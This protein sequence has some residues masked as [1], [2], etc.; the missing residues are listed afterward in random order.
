MLRATCSQLLLALVVWSCPLAA[1]E[2]PPPEVRTVGTTSLRYVVRVPAGHA[3][4]KWVPML[5]VFSSERGENHASAAAAG[6]ASVVEAG[7]VV[8]APVLE[9]QGVPDLRPLFTEL[10]RM[11]RIDQGGMHVLLQGDGEDTVAV[12]LAHRHQFQTVSSAAPL[13]EALTRLPARRI[14]RTRA[15]IPSTEVRRPVHFT[16]L[17]AERTLPGVAGEIARVLD[18]FHD[19]AANADEARYFAILPDDAVFLGTDGTERWTGTEFRAFA[20]RYFERES[21]WTYVTLRREVNVEPGDTIA[22]FDESFDNEAYG[23]CRGSGVMAKR[24]G[25]WVL[26]QYH[27]TVP[28]P[29][30]VTREVAARIRAF[31][32]G[33]TMGRDPVT[34]I[35][36]VRHAEKADAGEDPELS[37]AGS[38]R[39]EALARALRDVPLAA[40]YTS[41]FRRTTATVRE[42]TRPRGITPVQMP[43]KD[44]AALAAHLT[45]NHRGGT[46]LVCAHSNTVPAIL[47][48][49][50]VPGSVTIADDEYDRL[51]IVTLS[52]DGARMLSLRY[53]P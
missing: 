36:L 33:V 2:P 48:E 11:F 18:D 6:A 12:V 8:V 1:Q 28:V 27:L 49:L 50:G 42:I 10:R 44:H 19:A 39:A 5:V 14:R 35:V 26:R 15:V 45:E 4:E 29:N 25:K 37:D 38:K 17:H 46:V 20:T 34:T 13:A 31:Q 43:A 53:G 40:V 24:D 47:K 32:D 21:A 3:P 52:S 41:Q 9:G 23:E 30:D 22:W 51:F 16:A 7:F